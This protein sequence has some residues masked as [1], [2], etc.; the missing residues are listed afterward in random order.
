V[1][2]FV[3]AVTPGALAVLVA[4]LIATSVLG[5]RASQ[6]AGREAAFSGSWSA[7]GRRQTLPTGTNQ[8]AAIVTLSGAVV[9]AQPGGLSAG[10]RGE[11]IGYDDGRGMATGRAVWTDDNGNRVFSELRGDPLA[12]GRRIVGT[13]TGGTGRY[14]GITGTYELTW[15]Y[16]VRGEDDVVQGRA[17]DLRG[18]ARIGGGA[19]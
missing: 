8:D 14:Q 13:I 12:T 10:F 11:A 18:R 3:P 2:R 1:R 9:L 4:L 5:S 16:V 15:Q 7:T 6:L 17:V 19:P